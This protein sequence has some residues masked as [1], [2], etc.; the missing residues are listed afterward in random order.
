MDKVDPFRF[1]CQDPKAAAEN[2]KRIRERYAISWWKEIEESGTLPAGTF[3]VLP[4]IR[5]QRAFILTPD[6]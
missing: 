6:D 5:K 3:G 4:Q 1:M 2:R